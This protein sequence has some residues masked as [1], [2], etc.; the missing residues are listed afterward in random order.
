MALESKQGEHKSRY[1]QY[2]QRYSA[3]VSEMVM[4]TLLIVR[5]A[6]LDRHGPRKAMC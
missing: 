5:V 1:H 6:I 4:Y 2:I 3:Y